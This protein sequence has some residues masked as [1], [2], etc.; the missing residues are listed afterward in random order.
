M[1]PL[2]L[3]AKPKELLAV[4]R[5]VSLVAERLPHVLMTHGA[6]GHVLALQA[7]LLVTPA[8]LMH[9][10]VLDGAPPGTRAVCTHTLHPVAWACVCLCR[11][12][13]DLLRANLCQHATHLAGMQ[14]LW[15]SQLLAEYLSGLAHLAAGAV[16][17]LQQEA[18][19][20]CVHMQ[21]PRL[22]TAAPVMTARCPG[23]PSQT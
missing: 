19:S 20:G 8:V 21:S 22:R 1:Q 6:A 12:V 9:R 13:Q 23:A 14:L 11:P 16:G 18:V 10:R 17:P 7:H 4:L 15:A 2:P 5:V 3:A